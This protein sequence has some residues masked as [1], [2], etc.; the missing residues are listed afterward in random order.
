MN[1][2]PSLAR[3]RTLQESIMDA[4]KAVSEIES[5]VCRL[6][7]A[8]EGEM[9]TE[10]DS[11]GEPARGMRGSA[12]YLVTRLHSLLRDVEIASAQIVDSPNV[13]EF[14]KFQQGVNLSRGIVAESVRGPHGLA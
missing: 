1:P 5:V 9:S 6:Y 7:G 4:H 12:D 10:T 8:L 2:A 14:A 3:V 11:A 13:A